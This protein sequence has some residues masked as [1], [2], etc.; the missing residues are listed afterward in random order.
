ML[1][2][3]VA[4]SGRRGLAARPV[5]VS[6][7]GLAAAAAAGQRILYR[8]T[9]GGQSDLTF[10]EAVLQ[11]LGTDK[12]LL[13]PQ[14][15]PRFDAAT[16][17][18][19]RGLPFH[20]LAAEVM[21][22]YLTD[23]DLS[24]SELEALTAASYGAQWRDEAVTP[25]TT[26]PGGMRL[27]ELHHGP[28]FAFKDVALQFLG[29]L[30]ELLLAKREA[31][32][33]SHTLTVAGA[34][35]GDTGSSAIHGLRGKRGVEVFMMY[36]E[37]RTSPTQELQMISVLD[38]NIHNIALAGTFDDC[39]NI[40]KALFNDHAFRDSVGL[41]AVNSI[42]W[43]R[44]LAQTVY[45]VHAYHE[46][47]SPGAALEGTQVSYSVPTGN[48]GDIL[49][50]WYAKQMGLPVRKLIVATNENDILHRFFQAG[51]YSQLGVRET[52]SPSMDIQISSNFERF[53]FHAG[54]DD[55]PA[56][57]S[58]MDGLE[59]TKRLTPP[60]SLLAAC[61]EEMDSE[62]V[63]DAEV[64]ATIADVHTASA[65][66]HTLDPHSAIAVAGA[67]RYLQRAP[68]EAGVPMVALA[69][70]HWAKFASAVG[71][72]I[73]PEEAAKLEMPEP[74]A[75]L[76][77]KPTR[78]APLPNDVSAV[79]QHIHATLAQAHESSDQEAVGA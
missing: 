11:G 47:T 58:L 22:L 43:A 13:V 21:S 41:A 73:G 36:P 48:F 1:L 74:L 31:A 76:H 8:S 52:L 28:T 26:L 16:L 78:V 63:D 7:R 60:P 59:D 44:I 33:L 20:A 25:V 38:A 75:S 30:F 32:G 17:E 14:A 50:G 53:L 5:R 65:G 35:S 2:R 69:C 77:G 15:I 10:S 18:S 57:K 39:Q 29:N 67:R 79:R 4:Q 6:A 64:L 19:W 68:E 62:R 42:N 51:D 70:A 46:A 34:T 40:V 24:R 45:Y 61:R 49:A 71:R 72:A 56:L 66:E 55:A 9:R 37:G 3:G 54:G 23:D 12:G 27:L